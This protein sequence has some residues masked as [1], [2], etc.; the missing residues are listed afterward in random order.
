M[1]SPLVLRLL[2]VC[3]SEIECL[4]SNLTTPA[5]VSEGKAEVKVSAEVLS[6]SVR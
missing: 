3:G 5:L 6:V 1:D 4:T 2:N